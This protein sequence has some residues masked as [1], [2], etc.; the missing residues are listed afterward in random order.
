MVEV[1]NSGMGGY[2]CDQCRKLLYAGK[3]VRHYVYSSFKEDIVEEGGLKF[4]STRCKETYK[5]RKMEN[6]EITATN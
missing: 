2:I 1:F 5:N 4:C 3:T 6:G